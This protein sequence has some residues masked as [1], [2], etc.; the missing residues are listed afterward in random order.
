MKIETESNIGGEIA[1]SVD[2]LCGT[3]D[4]KLL[5]LRVNTRNIMKGKSLLSYFENHKIALPSNIQN[6]FI[7]IFKEYNRV[8]QNLV[9]KNMNDSG[10]YSYNVL[11]NGD[12][13]NWIVQIDLKGLGNDFINS[14]VSLAP[15][16]VENRIKGRIF[17]ID[18]NWAAYSVHAHATDPSKTSRYKHRTM[19]MLAHLRLKTAKKIILLSLTDE[20]YLSILSSEFGL[21]HI[22]EI[23]P[24]IVMDLT[25][26]DD[27]WGAREFIHHVE[28]IK[29]ID[30]YLFYVR[31]SDPIR[32]L[33]NP[34]AK[35]VHPL[36]SVEKYKRIIKNK[37]LT[38][39]ID[40][41]EWSLDDA[42]RINDTKMYLPAMGIADMIEDA[43]G[44]TFLQSK[45]GNIR[46]RAKPAIGAYGCYGHLSGYLIDKKFRYKLKT[47]MQNWG[48]YIIQPEYEPSSIMNTVDECEYVYMDRVFCGIINQKEEYFGGLRV[49]IPAHS[50]EV[51]K[52]R[53]HITSEAVLGEIY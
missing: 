1:S 20:K 35:I 33:K 15:N 49:Y 42:R 30:D 21:K 17:E 31:S 34:R 51:K 38:F 11:E 4:I 6:A 9:S 44:F 25:G 7:N 29:D 40:D 36:L 41:I 5:D 14:C 12:R 22:G 8:F 46:L 32:K 27:F 47:G 39:N 26:F 2:H 28:N 48:R 50:F 18:N 37:S 10:D 3:Q 23:S 24:D 43:R 19:A 45:Y 53:L 52:R 13:V 16:A